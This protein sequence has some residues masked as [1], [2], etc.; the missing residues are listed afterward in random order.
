[1]NSKRKILIVDDD[2]EYLKSLTSIL[3]RDFFIIAASSPKDARNLLLSSPD[4]ALL[5]IRLD[6]SDLNNREGIE[7]LKFVKNEIPTVPVVMMTAFGDID[8]AVEAMRLGAADFI[9]KAKID[10][11]EFR[12]VIENALDKSKLERKVSLLEEDL[13]HLEPWTIIGDDPKIL[14]LKKAIN[15]VAQD[16]QVTVLICGDTGT[17]KEL[18]ARAIHRTGIRQKEPFVPL[19]ISA[20]SPTTVESELFGHEKGSFTG[21]N[22]RKI[23]YIEKA[24]GGILFLDEI[25]ELNQELQIKLLRFMDN[26]IFNRM[27]STDEITV[28]LQLIAATNKNL[29]KAVENSS[30]RADLYY[31]LKASQIFLPTLAERVEDISKLA[32]HFLDLFRSQGRTQIEKISDSAMQLLKQYSWPGNVRE[33][34]NCIERAII[35]AGCKGHNLIALDDLPHE[36]QPSSYINTQPGTT[37]IPEGGIDVAQELAKTELNYIEQALRNVDGKK[38]EA[39]KLLKYN[40]RFAIRR[41]IEILTERYPH[42]LDSFPYTKKGYPKD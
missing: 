32:N 30:F 28:D 8:L 5:D 35:F 17:G 6:E 33:L 40:D 9:Q 27:G 39:W 19:A 23:G 29:K 2:A 34:K 38:T 22:S 12:K 15:A 1:M 16:G 20:L 21:A 4:L 37:G 3:K 42:L 10:I 26:K 31:R 18:V 25:G 24:S 36:I 13:H 41:R 14:E 7:I 11:R